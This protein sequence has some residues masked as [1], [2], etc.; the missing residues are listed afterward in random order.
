VEMGGYFMKVKC[1]FPK[2]KKKK[3][4]KEVKKELHITCA[5]NIISSYFSLNI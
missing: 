5:I 2:K 1:N 3:K 4:K